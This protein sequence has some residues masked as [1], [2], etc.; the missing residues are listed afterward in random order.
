MTTSASHPSWVELLQS[1]RDTV[2]SRWVDVAAA[3]LAGRMTRSELERDCRD[4]FDGIVAAERP[5]AASGN[6]LTGDGYADLR[7]LLAEVSRTRARQ[8]FTPTETA[9]R[10]FGL[11]EAVLVG[12]R[13]AR[14]TPRATAA[15]P[16][17]RA[18]S[19]TSACSCS[20]PTPPP[21]RA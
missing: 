6:G 16:P 5:P 17:S 1:H 8:G 20:R 18:A 14:T 11:K 21:A 13:G 12:P 2:L 19:T 10:V 15:S 4:I 7:G 3:T 9:I